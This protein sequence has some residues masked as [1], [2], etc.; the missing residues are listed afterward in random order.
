MTLT[1]EKAGAEMLAAYEA[2]MSGKPITSAQKE[3]TDRVILAG[4]YAAAAYEKYPF[5]EGGAVGA[6]TRAFLSALVDPLDP[7]LDYLREVP[8]A[9]EQARAERKAGAA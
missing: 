2:F 5:C 7:S 3:L 8:A 4:S 9:G 1:A 6:L